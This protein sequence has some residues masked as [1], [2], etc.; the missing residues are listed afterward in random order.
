MSKK[1]MIEFLT[2][3]H[4]LEGS[5]HAENYYYSDKKKPYFE[6]L[7][8]KY[9]ISQADFDSSLVWYTRRP[10]EF[11][12]MYVKVIENLEMLEKD[13]QALKFHPL[14][15]LALR[16]SEQTLWTADSIS[17]LITDSLQRRLNITLKDND[18]LYR[19]V[20]RLHFLQRAEKR[21]SIDTI[22]SVIKIYYRNQTADSLVYPIKLDGKTR[23]IS[24]RIAA[25]QKSPIDSLSARLLYNALPKDSLHVWLDSIRLIR[26]YDF[27]EQDTL[28]KQVATSDTILHSD[29][30]S[31]KNVPIKK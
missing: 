15:S 24:L 1:E 8:A 12:K 13:V 7:F 28:R 29:T 10:K 9:Q 20:Y 6:S 31:I 16:N 18:L 2:E 27:F 21:D 5:L 22:R 30:I 17:G 11:E 25:E 14:D 23:R 4:K 26:K 3:Y 19:D